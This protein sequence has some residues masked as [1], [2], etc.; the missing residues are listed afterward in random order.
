MYVTVST[1][2]PYCELYY[3]YTA[4]GG[5]GAMSE[6]EGFGPDYVLPNETGKFPF[7]FADNKMH[8]TPQ[9]ILKPAPPSV[10]SSS[11]TR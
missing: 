2:A 10:W 4:Q 3:S 1:Q 11:R 7:L 9:V 8:V 6:W 5:L